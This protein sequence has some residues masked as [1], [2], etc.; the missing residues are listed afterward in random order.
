MMMVD[1]AYQISY[2]GGDVVGSWIYGSSPA[3]GFAY[4]VIATTVIYALILPVL[5]LVPKA[6]IATADAEP[7]PQIES[8]VLAKIAKTAPAAR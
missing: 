4:C 2:R 7:N 3:H 1:G 8:N 5:V 6:L